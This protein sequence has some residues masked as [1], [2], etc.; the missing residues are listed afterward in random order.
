[1][2][3]VHEASGA[4]AVGVL[5]IAVAAALLGYF[6]ST[7]VWRYWVAS[8]WRDRRRARLDAAP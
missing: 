8:R 3:W 7:L 4:I 2:F 1:L 6:G 5:T